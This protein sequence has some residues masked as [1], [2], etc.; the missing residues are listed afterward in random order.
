MPNSCQ[1]A[2]LMRPAPDV[3]DVRL[4]QPQHSTLDVCQ[5]GIIAKACTGAGPYA[6]HPDPVHLRPTSCHVRRINPDIWGMVPGD[7]YGERLF[8]EAAAQNGNLD[9]VTAA[10]VSHRSS[11]VNESDFQL[12]SKNGINAVRAGW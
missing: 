8:M 3:W 2:A 5:G 11:Y 10:I 6:A 4:V 7:P 12:M 1:P 9:D